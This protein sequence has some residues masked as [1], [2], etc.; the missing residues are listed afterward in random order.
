ME[1]QKATEGRQE[2]ISVTLDA[3][4]H[5]RAQEAAWAEDRPLAAWIRVAIREKLERGENRT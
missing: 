5:E 2:R 4:L 1:Q 3:A